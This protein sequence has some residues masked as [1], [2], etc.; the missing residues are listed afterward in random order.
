MIPGEFNGERRKECNHRGFEEVAYEHVRASAGDRPFLLL[1]QK[2]R[3]LS[4]GSGSRWPQDRHRRQTE[5]GSLLLHTTIL[6]DSQN[7]T[8]SRKKLKSGRK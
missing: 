2:Q 3:Q 8:R 1:H 5:E 6:Q 7:K 4:Q